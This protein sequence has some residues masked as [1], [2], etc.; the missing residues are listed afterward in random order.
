[1]KEKHVLYMMGQ[2]RMAHKMNFDV[3]VLSNLPMVAKLEDLF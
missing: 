2:D 3:Q 1:M